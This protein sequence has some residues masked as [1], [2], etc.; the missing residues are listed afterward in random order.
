[1]DGCATPVRCASLREEP[2]LSEMGCG[3]HVGR[4]AL[5]TLAVLSTPEVLRQQRLQLG[6]TTAVP[7]SKFTVTS[8]TNACGKV[9]PFG[10]SFTAAAERSTLGMPSSA[11]IGL[12]REEPSTL[13]FLSPSHHLRIDEAPVDLLFLERLGDVPNHSGA[14]DTTVKKAE[15][16]FSTTISPEDEVLQKLA[17]HQ[18]DYAPYASSTHCSSVNSVTKELSVD[19]GLS[20]PAAIGNFE[21]GCGAEG[22]LDV[23][24]EFEPQSVRCEGPLWRTGSAL[25]SA[26]NQ[27]GAEPAVLDGVLEHGSQQRNCVAEASG[28]ELHEPVSV[29]EAMLSP[30]TQRSEQ[31]RSE[32]AMWGVPM[33]RNEWFRLNSRVRAIEVALKGHAGELH[34]KN[35]LL[36]RRE[37]QLHKMR[38]ANRELRRMLL[39]AH[40][41]FDSLCCSLLSSLKLCQDASSGPAAVKSDPTR[42]NTADNGASEKA[43][44]FGVKS[45]PA[46]SCLE[47]SCGGRG[48]RHW[49]GIFPKRVLVP[50]CRR[51]WLKQDD[52]AAAVRYARSGNA[53]ASM[54]LG[55]RACHRRC[56]MLSKK[57]QNTLANWQRDCVQRTYC[58]GERE[59]VVGGPHFRDAL[60]ASPSDA[61]GSQKCGQVSLSSAMIAMRGVELS[62]NVAGELDLGD[63]RRD[64]IS[65]PRVVDSTDAKALLEEMSLRNT[66]LSNEVHQL[67]CLLAEARSEAQLQ[68]HEEFVTLQAILSA[69]MSNV[70]ACAASSLAD[71]IT[72]A[73]DSSQTDFDTN[74]RIVTGELLAGLRSRVL[75][76]TKR[77]AT[78]LECFRSRVSG[79]LFR[80]EA[81]DLTAP[82]EA[83]NGLVT[84][85]DGNIVGADRP[86]TGEAPNDCMDQWL[87]CSP[88]SPCYGGQEMVPSLLLHAR[89]V[90]DASD[91]ATLNPPFSPQAHRL[92]LHAAL[93]KEF[94]SASS[95][96]V[97]ST[98]GVSCSQ[99]QHN[100]PGHSNSSTP[101]QFFLAPF[102]D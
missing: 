82:L 53:G 88:R 41:G 40:H 42:V 62:S 35:C 94:C 12:L 73:V 76:V 80:G 101:P 3:A 30:E 71:P 91:T 21:G 45:D 77:S 27:N 64:T 57:I 2:S 1:M 19:E 65:E 99:S 24:L 36:R 15:T 10:F 83:A 7:A 60:A 39:Y 18:R 85:T 17:D 20:F 11:S 33:D 74:S 72:G 81:Q 37:R 90:K 48:E 29:A 55:V 58:V 32:V 96:S 59:I 61:A 23:G 100:A 38:G 4:S 67:K 70:S 84:L 68:K 25:Y 92:E 75:A 14:A 93:G 28:E 66:E 47:A 22:P 102:C 34:R 43:H 86:N 97:S 69:H 50:V 31:G 79:S 51:R 6:E 63:R 5:E 95:P 56:E 26:A 8:T 16:L 78:E 44:N 89:A 13:L 46:A 54:F 52:P 87:C 9:T 49:G 98:S